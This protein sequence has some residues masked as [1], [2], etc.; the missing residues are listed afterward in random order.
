MNKFR[1]LAASIAALTTALSLSVG[2]LAVTANEVKKA[3]DTKPAYTLAEKQ[4][5][6]SYKNSGYDDIA[7]F[8]IDNDFSVSDAQNTMKLYVEGKRME[9][10]LSNKKS[11]KSG[12]KS[13]GNVP[14]FYSET[15]MSGKQHY[16]VVIMNNGSANVRKTILDLDYDSDWAGITS[17]LSTRPLHSNITVDVDVDEDET[18]ANFECRIPSLSSSNT[19]AGV[20]EFPFT[21]NMT[22]TGTPS[23]TFTESN[24]YSTFD[25]T[26]SYIKY[27]SGSPN[28][29]FDFETYVQGDINHDGRVDGLDVSFMVEYNQGKKTLNDLH[30][31]YIGVSANVAK[32]INTLAADMDHNGSV[33]LQDLILIT[34]PLATD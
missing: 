30:T 22:S 9:S 18:E 8:L 27:Y 11:F 5:I 23:G 16:G 1:K 3:I 32:I 17:S 31:N 13:S 26:R 28:T 24:L 2:T 25:L 14:K 6:D 7:A 20:F 21:L 19:P 15:N 12:I 29:T 33:D 4:F 34:R 10:E